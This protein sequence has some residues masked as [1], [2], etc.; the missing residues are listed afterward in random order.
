[1]SKK[2]EMLMHQVAETALER[3]ELELKE[4]TLKEALLAEFNKEGIDK[5]KNEYG[6]FS[7]KTY[8][9]YTFSNK[10]T[11]LKEDLELKKH[12]EIERGVATV[13]YTE[14]LAFLP[15]KKK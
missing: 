14:S 12:E 1:M 9:R 4:K 7:K 8:P 10:V 13:E 6:T 2:A 11:K 3:K 5:E 15:V